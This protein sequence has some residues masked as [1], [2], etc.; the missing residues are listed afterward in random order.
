SD[1][2]WALYKAAPLLFM[3]HGSHALGIARAAV[4]AATEIIIS[5]RGWGDQPL[6]EIPRLQLMIAEATALVESAQS[7]LYESARELWAA[8]TAGVADTTRSRARVRLATS[9]AARASAQAV[10][11]VHAA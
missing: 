4:V 3:N 1:L 2:P 5:R 10:D 9:H 11:V 8:T 6:R 7:Y